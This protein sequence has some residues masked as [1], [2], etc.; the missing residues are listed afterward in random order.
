MN[1][2]SES[3]SRVAELEARQDE[4]LRELAELERRL[5]AVLAEVLP[6]AAGLPP[7]DSAVPSLGLVCSDE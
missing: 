5:D 3:F 1:D 6:P 2:T 7:L 4:V